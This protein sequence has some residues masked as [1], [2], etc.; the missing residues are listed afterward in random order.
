M[1]STYAHLVNVILVIGLV[2]LAPSL[3]SATL[4]AGLALAAVLYAT[5]WMIRMLPRRW[6]N[7]PDQAAY[8]ALSKADQQRVL[9]VVQ[10][11]LCWETA[12]FLAVLN[13]VQG[14][15]PYAAMPE[16]RLLVIGFGCFA[17]LSAVTMPLLF[18]RVQAKIDELAPPS[19]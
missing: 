12:G 3:A 8:D 16:S 11:A 4:H 15:L 18:V 14:A 17:G 5:A 2:A 19:P 10:R 1:P 6:I 7:M 13:G 9:G